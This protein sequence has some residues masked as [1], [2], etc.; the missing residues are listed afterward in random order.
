VNLPH[1]GHAGLQRGDRKHSRLVHLA[2]VCAAAGTPESSQRALLLSRAPA[3]PG[4]GGASGPPLAP[5]LGTLVPAAALA[6]LA[7]VLGLWWRRRRRRERQ[8]LASSE[9]LR[10]Q[11]LPRSGSSLAAAEAGPPSGGRGSSSGLFPSNMP[12]VEEYT[13]K[14]SDFVVLQRKDG[15]DWLLGQGAFGKARR[16]SL[17]CRRCAA[18]RFPVLFFAERGRGERV[19]RLH[20]RPLAPPAG[21]GRTGALPAGGVF[22]VLHSGTH[23]VRMR[24]AGVVGLRMWS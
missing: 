10:L 3:P 9:K 7:A 23:P 24:W 14:P 15:A 6:M 16:R 5:I 12:H 21:L 13:V 2:R 17:V 19:T 20:G 11:S 8:K 1:C 4:A 22:A 18:L